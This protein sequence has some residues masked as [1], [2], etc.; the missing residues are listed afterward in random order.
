RLR[1]HARLLYPEVR[2]REP[3]LSD[4]AG[5]ALDAVIPSPKPRQDRQALASSLTT[6]S[7]V[8]QEQSQQQ[9]QE[10]RSSRPA[11]QRP[12]RPDEPRGAAQDAA[13]QSTEPR[14]ARQALASSLT[15]RS[16]V[17]QE[18]SQQQ[19]QERRSSL[20]AARRP[21]GFDELRDG[22]GQIRPHQRLLAK[23]LENKE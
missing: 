3:R 16:R 2:R 4:D 5:P 15:T 21:D 6:R 14:Q 17:E 18:Q 23:F 11:A 19:T 22:A 12:D 9:T 20:P 10:R 7:R 13:S 8:E 1:T